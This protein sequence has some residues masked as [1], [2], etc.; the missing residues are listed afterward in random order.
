MRCGGVASGV[1]WTLRR[2]NQA[3]EEQVDDVEKKD[4]IYDLLRS[5]RNLFSWVR[6]LRGG[7]TCELST[8]IGEGCSD[9]NAAEAVE[10][11]QKGM[12]WRFPGATY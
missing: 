6:C 1:C 10:A 5:P 4:T 3:H 12:M 2:H 7:Q 11:V 9:K 8:G